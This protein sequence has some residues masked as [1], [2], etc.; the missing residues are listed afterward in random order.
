VVR[1][2]V[3]SLADVDPQP[4]PPGRLILPLPATQPSSPRC[5]EPVIAAVAAGARAVSESERWGGEDFAILGLCS[6]FFP[7]S[8]YRFVTTNWE[9]KVNW[10][11]LI[12]YTA[13][14]HGSR[15]SLGRLGRKKFLFSLWARQVIWQGGSAPS[16]KWQSRKVEPCVAQHHLSLYNPFG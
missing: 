10:M 5:L 8:F 13:R 6:R 4:R 1:D 14:V 3:W 11:G 7:P 15:P 2:S 9:C 16:V 12:S